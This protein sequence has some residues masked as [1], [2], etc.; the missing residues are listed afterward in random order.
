MLELCCVPSFFSNADQNTPLD[1]IPHQ[2]Y[3]NDSWMKDF[4][5]I[6][7]IKSISQ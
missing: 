2:K 5:N 4:D 7:P 1:R 3:K 6:K